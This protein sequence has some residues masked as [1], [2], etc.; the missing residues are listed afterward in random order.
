MDSDNYADASRNGEFLSYYRCP[1][2]TPTHPPSPSMQPS[3]SLTFTK[4]L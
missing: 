4:A 3:F 2:P 1:R